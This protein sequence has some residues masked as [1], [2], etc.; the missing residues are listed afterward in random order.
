M[1]TVDQIVSA[2]KAQMNTLF[3]LG[4][5]AL[6]SVEKITE[7][8]MQ[9]SKASLAEGVRDVQ[10]LM[11]AKDLQELWA[12]QSNAMQ[13]LSDKA[14]SYSRHLYDIASSLSSEMSQAFESQA[15]AGQKQLMATVETAV[16]SAPQGS[17]AAVA[18]VQNAIASATAAMESVQKAVKQATETAEANFSAIAATA[19]QSAK[20]A[21][22]A[23]AA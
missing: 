8:N 2:Q 12:L 1:M 16:K 23:K 4:G 5:K 10:A 18:V 14:V 7:L 11:G 13:P 22:T 17:E 3:Q 20:P 6:Q 21:K 9:A 15:A 19:A